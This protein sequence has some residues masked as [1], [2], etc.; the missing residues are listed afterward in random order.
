MKSDPLHTNPAGKYLNREII[1]ILFVALT[2][3]L[4]CFGYELFNFSLSIDEELAA[5]HYNNNYWVVWLRQGRWGMAILTSL[6]PADI[7]F[8][9]FVSTALFCF[10]TCLAAVICS[11]LFFKGIPGRAAFCGVFVSNPIMPHLAEF[12]TFAHG[13]GMG[14]LLCAVGL[15][16]VFDKR[17]IL[18][19]LS[20]IFFTLAIA[21]YQSFI[22]FLLAAV[23]LIVCIQW[24]WDFRKRLAMVCIGVFIVTLSYV[25]SGLIGNISI[26]VFHL[27]K[28]DYFSN[29]MNLKDI[30]P[31]LSQSSQV[32]WEILNGGRDFYLNLGA[33][34]LLPVWIGFIT[35]SLAIFF[36]SN[37]KIPQFGLSF[38]LIFGAIVVCYS[39]VLLSAG[40]IPLR[41][42]LGFTIMFPFLAAF[43]MVFAKLRKAFLPI[44]ILS[45]LCS[46]SISNSLF[47]KDRLARIRDH[48]LALSLY[49]KLQNLEP[50]IGTQPMSFTVIG[51]PVFLEPQNKQIEVFGSS[52]FTHEGG[53]PFR[54]TAYLKSLGITLLNPILVST[55]LDKSAILNRPNWPHPDSLFK[56]CEVL[57]VKFEDIK[58]PIDPIKTKKSSELHY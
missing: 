40:R 17:L 14:Y 54:V 9:P 25:L 42:L 50:F 53:N 7:S 43:P 10:G 33:W 16:M 37:N 28:S 45:I 5:Y 52:F 31:S 35:L 58:M 51:K 47:Y 46:A 26:S 19:V 39:L 1:L 57:V 15:W 6:L 21:I 36:K 32:C 55:I 27:S 20:I 11:G 41:A 23:L 49:L 24:D 13:V 8:M 44:L 18:N 34:L 30:I 29:Y 12:N 3:S 22:F 56:C 4:L 48:T 38:L 2:F